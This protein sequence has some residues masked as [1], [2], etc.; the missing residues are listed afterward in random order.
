MPITALRNL[1]ERRQLTVSHLPDFLKRMSIL[2]GEGY[3]FADCIEMLL[4][5]HVKKYSYYEERIQKVLK[6]GGG[7]VRIMKLFGL[8]QQYL[9]AIELAEVTGDLRGTLS[10]IADQIHFHAETKKKLVKVLTYPTVLFVSLIGLFLVFRTY[11]LPNMSSMVSSRA[12]GEKTTSIEWATFFLHMPDYFVA[13]GVVLVA[14]IVGLWL[15]IQRKRVDLQLNILFKIPLIGHFWRL[16]LTRQFARSLGSLLRTGVSLQ[17]ALEYLK[18]QPH[19]KQ[20][21]YVAERIQL[22]VIYGESLQASIFLCGYFYP[23]FEQFVA[24][25]E[26]SGLLGRELILYSELL[27]ARLQMI[28]QTLLVFI[29]P[30]MF[31]VIAACVVAAYLSILIPMYS[32]LDFV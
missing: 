30:L 7:S 5:Y 17:Q 3:S 27:D 19:Q 28:V 16:L 25:G 24:H 32:L 4:P 15:Y 21:A 10:Q 8:E 20:L 1:Q 18:S 13:L 29:Q 6:D 23:R 11:F 31:I 9:V 14:G 12:Q 2:L 26:A 22:R